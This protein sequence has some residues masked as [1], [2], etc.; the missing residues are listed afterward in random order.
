MKTQIKSVLTARVHYLLFLLACVL[1]TAVV[2]RARV[3]TDQ[4][5]SDILAAINQISLEGGHT[6]ED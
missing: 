2:L 1:L 3:M 4:I 6:V 5:S